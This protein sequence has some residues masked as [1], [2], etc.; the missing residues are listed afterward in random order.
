MLFDPGTP[1]PELDLQSRLMLSLGVRSALSAYF[2]RVDI[3]PVLIVD[4]VENTSREN[5]EEFNKILLEL[6]GN[7]QVIIFTSGT[8]SGTDLI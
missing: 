2:A 1:L 4:P 8:D 5:V 6:F 3:P 7:R